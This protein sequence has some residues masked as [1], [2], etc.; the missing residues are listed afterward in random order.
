VTISLPPLLIVSNSAKP[1]DDTAQQTAAM[2]VVLVELPPDSTVSVSP[3][4]KVNAA[5]RLAGADD[6]G[7]ISSALPAA[8]TVGGVDDCPRRYNYQQ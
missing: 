5:A 4:L 8:W 3:E 6:I 7:V 1:P 2:I